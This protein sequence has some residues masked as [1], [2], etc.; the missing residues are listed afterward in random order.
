MTRLNFLMVM[1]LLGFLWLPAQ[2][3]QGERLHLDTTAT[4]N[5]E[6]FTIVEVPPTFPGGMNKLGEYIRTNLK[7]PEAARKAGQEGRVFVSFIV[8]E[9]GGIEEVQV[10]KSLGPEL[11]AEAKRLIEKMPTWIPGKQ[12][13][14]AVACRFN[15]PVNFRIRGSR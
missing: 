15:L 12:A 7:Y 13:G 1:T 4:A 10:L 3:Q 14:R 9:V 11:D 2:A 8:N 5:R 6:V